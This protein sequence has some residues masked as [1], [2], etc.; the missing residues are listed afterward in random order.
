MKYIFSFN[1]LKLVIDY[2]C[3]AQQFDSNLL[4]VTCYYSVDNIETD[5]FTYT[6]CWNKNKSVK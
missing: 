6:I 1:F 3:Q 5:H 4:P 2:M